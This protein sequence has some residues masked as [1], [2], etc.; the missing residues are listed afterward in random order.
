MESGWTQSHVPEEFLPQISTL[1]PGNKPD[2]KRYAVA[3]P[4][5]QLACCKTFPS[6][7]LNVGVGVIVGVDVIVGVVVIVGVSETVGV[8]VIMRVGVIVSIGVF[9]DVVVGDGKDIKGLHAWMKNGT[10]KIIS[11]IG[12]HLINFL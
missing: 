3:G 8:S 2:A 1:S 5:L 9:V 4:Y 12:I 6:G 11:T 7:K 10:P